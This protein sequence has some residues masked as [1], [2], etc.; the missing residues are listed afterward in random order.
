MLQK[1]LLS[2]YTHSCYLL[3]TSTYLTG[4][5]CARRE[6]RKSLFKENY[7]QIFVSCFSAGFSSNYENHACS[8]FLPFCDNLIWCLLG[9][10]KLIPLEE[11]CLSRY[12]LMLRSSRNGNPFYSA[13]DLEQR[14]LHTCPQK[15]RNSSI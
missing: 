10:W 13:T 7:S 2:L 1:P 4:V 6:S 5:T 11:I 9:I 8:T 14:T 15:I 12:F 3:L